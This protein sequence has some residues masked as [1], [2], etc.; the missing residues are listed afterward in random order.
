[1][2]TFLKSLNISCLILLASIVFYSCVSSKDASSDIENTIATRDSTIAIRAI[3]IHPNPYK[4]VIIDNVGLSIKL[5]H[6]SKP[7][8]KTGGGRR[9]RLRTL[10]IPD[11]IHGYPIDSFDLEVTYRKILPG[12]NIYDPNIFNPEQPYKI[13]DPGS[14]LGDT[15][16]LPFFL[17]YPCCLDGNFKLRQ[18]WVLS[19]HGGKPP[20][21][22]CVEK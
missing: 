22:P 20:E 21:C 3:Y 13:G 19:S 1:M 8:L 6:K 14:Y 2:N 12:S 11:L 15:I 9:G 4:E 16:T 18:P 5:I 10:K 7:W 17:N